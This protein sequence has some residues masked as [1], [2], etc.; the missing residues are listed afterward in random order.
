MLR[1]G[2]QAR[3]AAA[4]HDPAAIQHDH[5]VGHV[6]DHAEVVGDVQDRHVQLVLEILHQLQNLRLDR[7][8]E[9][10]GRLVG[11]QQRRIADQGHGDHRALAQPARELE[12]IGPERLL[13]IGEADPRQ[14]LD[15]AQ[16]ALGA[17]RLGVQQQGLADLVADRVQGR[18]RAHRLLEDD[19]DP[20]APDRA[21]D[22]VVVGVAREVERLVVPARVAQDDLAAGDPRGLRQD[23]EDRLRDHGLAGAALADQS[24][25]LAGLDREAHAPDRLDH[26][27][28]GEKVDR[29]VL[30]LQERRRHGAPAEQLAGR[31]EPGRRMAAEHLEQPL[32]ETPAGLVHGQVMAQDA[33][34][35]VR[36]QQR[37]Q[38]LERHRLADEQAR[39]APVDRIEMDVD[40]GQ[41]RRRLA[42][43]PPPEGR[44]AG[45]AAGG[46]PQGQPR[47]EPVPGRHQDR[48]TSGAEGVDQRRATRVQLGR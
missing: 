24:D 35:L 10:G 20:A 29:Q 39:A 6:G 43:G 34:R 30:D 22:R 11:D 19:R 7:D 3:A 14:H 17:A 37:A 5:V 12:G 45:E 31:A 42:R 8:V 15:G 47:V 38:A 26:A 33:D 13:G 40:L 2:Q 4:L 41:P 21:P 23:A 32:E 28:V 9:R 44:E 25:R 18:E 27:L 46:Q 48:E 36:T 1:P 16:P